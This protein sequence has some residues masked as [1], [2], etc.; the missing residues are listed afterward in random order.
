LGAFSELKDIEREF[1]YIPRDLPPKYII[2]Q[3][4]GYVICESS[5]LTIKEAE[6]LIHASY[7]VNE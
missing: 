5:K 7:V 6:K 2:S 3:V 1:E 4:K